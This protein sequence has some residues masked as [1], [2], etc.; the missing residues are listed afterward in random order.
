MLKF[1]SN[2]VT[3]YLKKNVVVDI[4]V[5]PGIKTVYLLDE[6]GDQCSDV[7]CEF[8]IKKTNKSFPD[9]K[10][11][12][13]SEN[14]F[15]IFIPNMLFP[16]VRHVASKSS[17]FVDDT[18]CLIGIHEN[19]CI[20]KRTLLNSFCKKPG[21]LVSLKKVS[22]IND[23]ALLGCQ[24]SNFVSIEDIVVSSIRNSGFDV[25]DISKG[26]KMFGQALIG[27]DPDAESIE[28]PDD[29]FPNIRVMQEYICFTNKNKYINVHKAETLCKFEGLN[30]PGHI[31]IENC[32]DKDLPKYLSDFKF[33]YLEISGESRLYSTKDGVLYSKD[34]TAL[35]KYP[36]CKKGKAVIPEG[37]IRIADMA[38]KG[39][40]IDSVTMPNS[41]RYIGRSAFGYCPKLEE[42][43][44]NSNLDFINMDAFIGCERLK[45]VEIPDSIK[46]ISEGCFSKCPLEN[47]KMPSGLQSI[48]LEAF[49]YAKGHVI[50]PKSVSFIGNYNFSGVDTIT[51]EGNIPYG[52]ISAVSNFGMG[53]YKNLVEI[54]TPNG[55]FYL[56]KGFS[57]T[58]DNLYI[59]PVDD[60]KSYIYGNLQQPYQRPYQENVILE[61][62]EKTGDVLVGNTLKKISNKMV[63]RLIKDN[64]EDML[65]RIIRT[66]ILNYH[67]LQHILNKCKSVPIS[68]YALEQM[69]IVAKEDTFNV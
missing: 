59:F 20:G 58:D 63:K 57:V 38:F 54:E 2:G 37:V 27:I 47:I 19:C 35:I 60:I 62:Y 44:F 7:G 3:Y 67:Q 52:L 28:I 55:S 40:N 46:V 12:V 49:D 18:N 14:V 32:N 16:N 48:G 11:L 15:D 6:F 45:Q 21:E 42:I 69:S 33:S 64:N 23:N 4:D 56:P 24:T 61:L 43:N 13:I 65:I 34:G 41:L 1:K 36:D 29:R 53:N 39:C 25:K 22:Y 10:E 50:L 5:E 17:Y 51:V 66:G 31:I 68:A 30:I 26:V 9:V 8:N